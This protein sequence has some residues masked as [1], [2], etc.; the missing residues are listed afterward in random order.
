MTVSLVL[1]PYAM[2]KYSYPMPA[3]WLRILLLMILCYPPVEVS[4]QPASPQLRPF[5]PI[6]TT[7]SVSPEPMQPLFPRQANSL[8][9]GDPYR[10]QNYRAMQQG[11]MDIP[12]QPATNRQQ[13]MTALREILREEAKE[14]A[15]WVSLPF[16]N[17]LRQFLLLNPDNFSITKAVYLTESAYDPAIPPYEQF[18]AAIKEWADLV[19]QILKREGLSTTD[20]TAVNY[21]IQKLYSQSN[22][23]YNSQTKKYYT[24]SPLRY[25]FEDMMGDKDWKKMF[26][27]KLLQ[28]RTGQ[29]HS[30]PLFYLCVAEQL[31]T[32]A[33][34]SLSP[35][36]SFVQ[37]FD[38][39]GNR[40]NFETTNGNLVSQA[41]LAK[42][43]Y[44]N[45]TA[46]KNGTYL[47]TLSSN[48]L[49][50]QCVSDLL[51][52]YLM[53]IG[54]NQFSDRITKQ[55]LAIDSTNITALMT[56]ANY[57]YYIFRDELQ[58]AGNPPENNYP[59]YPR[60]NA[61]FGRLREA[62]QK[63]QQTGFQEM[64]QE[65]YQQWLKSLELE[66]QKQQNR[67]EQ[68]KL[69]QEIKRLKKIKSTFINK[70]NQ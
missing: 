38:E 1:T 64:P 47:D 26:V 32:K 36:H 52:G 9:P 41:W 15:E 16:Q 55:I 5:K 68:E 65:V 19:K 50:A 61:A 11:G 49:Y 4:A 69:A 37:H 27:S 23:Y 44:V 35:N 43:T 58:A 17:N 54:Y 53:K 31:N 18:E 7:Q 63:I 57:Y 2:S 25:D 67:I 12:G 24:I 62:R 46:L 39:K 40:Y 13:Q 33:Y 48:K 6:T 21:A 45:S 56:Q 20:N 34:L 42:S 29:C 22:T 28:T 30:L 3:Y 60:L 51:L 70:P 14:Q 10:E 59:D 8:L 66:K